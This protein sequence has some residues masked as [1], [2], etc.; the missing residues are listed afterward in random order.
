MAGGASR[1]KFSS[2][3]FGN[4]TTYPPVATAEEGKKKVVVI[5]D[6]SLFKRM[7]PLLTVQSYEV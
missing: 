6:H 1:A 2:Q 4:K 5:K 3:F 7:M